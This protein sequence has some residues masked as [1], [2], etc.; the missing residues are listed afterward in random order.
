MK[1]NGFT[2][3]E[4][5]A[6]ITVIG[7]IMVVSIPNI[8][9][10]LKNQK[11]DYMKGDAISMVE[12]A[13][14]KV[15][16]ERGLVKPR[17]GECIILTLNYLDDN[18]EIKNGPNGGKYDQFDSVVVY[19]RQD[20]TDSNNVTTKK[21]KYYVRLVEVI[22]EDNRIGFTITDSED[23]NSKKIADIEK[24]EDNI[25]LTKTM[26]LNE[27]RLQI[28]NFGSINSKCKIPEGSEGDPL[29]PVI[30]YYPGE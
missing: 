25:G 18:D 19:T 8:S 20:T 21:Y 22:S 26:T 1:K 9:G 13:K 27:A 2:L 3:V 7:I 10:I 12:A 11:L 16:K 17:N 28:D 30:A 29:N 6:M 24:I 14:T 15:S 5:L 4:V 23:I